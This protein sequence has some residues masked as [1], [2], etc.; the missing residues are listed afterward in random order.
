MTAETHSQLANPPFGVEWKQQ[1]KYIEQERDTLGY[2]GRFGAGL[3][4]IN[5]GALLF[6]QHMLDKRRA[7]QDGGSRIGKDRKA[8]LTELKSVDRELGIHLNVSELEGEIME[9]LAEVA[10]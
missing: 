6:L 7:P 1:Q 9:M 5:D 3:P 10:R 8:F 4:R 2:E